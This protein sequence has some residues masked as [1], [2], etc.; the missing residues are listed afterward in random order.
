M[1]KKLPDSIIQK[2]A[3]GEVITSLYSIIKELIENA[4]DAKSTRI[5]IIFYSNGD[6]KITDNGKG[7]NEE[8]LSLL[9]SKNCTSK[10]YDYMTGHTNGQSYGFRGEALFSISQISDI[11]VKTIVKSQ[12]DN[13]I[14][15]KG[16]YFNSILKGK[17][18]VP[19]NFPNGT[20]FM[21]SNIFKN[22]SYRKN[23]FIKKQKEIKKC[24][25]LIKSYNVGNPNTFIEYFME[26]K[27]FIH[28]EGDWG[29]VEFKDLVIR[30]FFTKFDRLN[31][32]DIFVLENNAYKIAIYQNFASN[33][34][35]LVVNGRLVHNKELKQ[36]IYKKGVKNLFVLVSLS[37]DKVDV[38][39]HPSK[40]KVILE[41]NGIFEIIEK[42]IN[43]VL[44]STIIST[45]I[46]EDSGKNS[47]IGE[48][49]KVNSSELNEDYSKKIYSDPK[50]RT[51]EECVE[52][53][54]PSE[55]LQ[56]DQEA[57][58]N[59]VLKEISYV[60]CIKENDDFIIFGQRNDQLIKFK[61]FKEIKTSKEFNLIKNVENNLSIEV[62]T[63]LQE[64]YRKF[65]RS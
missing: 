2:I 18:K 34:F 48:C 28:D 25:N 1:I 55:E 54:V 56:S 45:S 38:N 9:C 20:E 15:F 21:I 3:A 7:I 16:V 60:G 4:L 65:G 42:E 52:N 26:D 53:N 64:L 6:I 5:Q 49:N 39:V 27:Q 23:E 36:S 13:F 10:T 51:I 33:L 40:D 46:H 47:F 61:Y 62:L 57:K 32:D 22:N 59:L 37:V 63:D 35:N 8:D 41:S 11:E 58:N 31:K 30:E 12:D 50:I 17:I 29:K 43:N 19:M 24:I 44:Q 14:G